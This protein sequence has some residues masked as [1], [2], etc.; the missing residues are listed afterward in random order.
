[1]RNLQVELSTSV[2]FDHGEAVGIRI[3]FCP[4][5]PDE[6]GIGKH[7][8]TPDVPVVNVMQVELSV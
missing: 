3:I 2:T 1:M 4:E 8:V 7:L 5:F 6:L